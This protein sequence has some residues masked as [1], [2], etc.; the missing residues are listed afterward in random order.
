MGVA[1]VDP[2][3]TPVTD[4]TEGQGEVKGGRR[5]SGKEGGGGAKK[6]E[7]RLTA[8]CKFFHLYCF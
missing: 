3:F 8:V 5:R 6:R 7:R 1:E 4:K 2:D